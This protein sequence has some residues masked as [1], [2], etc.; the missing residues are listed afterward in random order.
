MPVSGTEVSKERNGD[1]HGW[2]A[3][4]AVGLFVGWIALGN[5]GPMFEL[6]PGVR[7]WYPPAALVAAAVT[8]WGARALVPII[9]AASVSAIAAPADIVPLW[10]I[11][12]VSAFL[13]VAY[14]AGARLLRRAGFD[15]DFSRTVD[16]ALFAGVFAATA[17]VTA[18]FALFDLRIEA[19]LSNPETLRL[20]RSFWIG[21]IV[22]VFAL[23]PAM[24]VAAPWLTARGRRGRPVPRFKGSRRE[25]AQVASIPVA[26]VLAAALA[27]SLGFF[28]YALCFLPLG[29]IALTHGPRIAALANV[30]FVL[31]A[32]WSVHDIAG[33]APKSLEVQVFAALLVLTGLMIGSV[34]EERERAFSLL[35][36]S[37]ERYRSL[38]DLLPDPIV[39]HERGRILFA[40]GAAA[41]VLGAATPAQ[42]TGRLLQDIAAPRSK[43][44]V[45]ERLRAL[46]NGNALS[47]VR[48]TVQRI[49]GSGTVEIEAVSI[50]FAYQ[51]LPAVLTVAR[52]VTSRLRLEEELRQAQRMEAVGRLAGGVAH[53]FNNLLTVITS[54]SELIL[55]GLEPGAPLV[56][57]VREI[58]HAADRAA[59]LTRQL[60]SFS[61]RQVLQ[62]A[63]VDIS[64]AVRSTEGLLRRLISSEIRIESHLDASAGLVLADRGQLEQVIVNL[65][66]NARDAMPDG[67]TLTIE[68]GSVRAGEDPATDRCPAQV[69][70]YAV[71]MVRDTGIGIDDATRR[72]IFDPFFTTKDVGRGTGLGL[73]TVHGIVEQSGGTI[74]VESVV[75][76]GTTFRIFLPAIEERIV[77]DLVAASP[78]P[79]TAGRGQGRVLLVEDEDA[80]RA[81]IHRTLTEAGYDVI[82]VSDG[83]EA[84]G[85]LETQASD[86]DVVLSDVA[87]P[88]M[89]GRQ[90]AD[91]VR[92]RWPS[93]PVVLMSGFANP[94]T[95]GLDAGVT[96][97]LLKPF[98]T[99]TLTA[100]IR[101][102][103]PVR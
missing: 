17:A 72:Q 13:K 11:L 82:D 30:V 69:A 38:V 14:W 12:L 87:M 68:T 95:L 94:D 36:Q 25:L 35:G 78:A 27:P 51:G 89:D 50:P 29:W 65:A 76:S 54:Y 49:D 66:V 8:Y 32:L 56:N 48:H 61:R 2:N 18:W 102:A 85:V 103:L 24:L 47:L 97:L 101:D 39:V 43:D 58:R 46:A 37:E 5:V 64:E 59:S 16:V 9:L 88:R 98:T 74:I 93:L 1:S 81:I 44:L 20:L 91:H 86:V 73:A 23:S 70:R 33:V 21:D 96:L 10:R 53:D 40:N 19:D 52:D 99:D 67:G 100:A 31:G 22:A 7:A 55:A 42:L 45:E 57:D 79:A 77:A 62:P 84:L 6:A 15:T 4:I 60:L 28:S 71:I 41:T 34:A 92:V 90:L 3:W 75:G 80:V 26:I 63:P 83:A